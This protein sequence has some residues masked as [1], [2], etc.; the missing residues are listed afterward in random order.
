MATN[1]GTAAS[2][3]PGGSPV[4]VDR[5]LARLDSLEQLVGQLQGDVTKIGNM[6]Q[7]GQMPD[8]KL[9][10]TDTP[11]EKGPTYGQLIEQG[12]ELGKELHK[13][14]EII[15]QEVKSMKG[16][17][18]STL[19]DITAKTEDKVR[20]MEK[21]LGQTGEVLAQHEGQLQGQ[22][23]SLGATLRQNGTELEE[24]LRKSK[25]E[26]EEKLWKVAEEATSKVNEAGNVL[27]LN[28]QQGVQAAASHMEGIRQ[29]GERAKTEIG[30]ILSGINNRVAQIESNIT[31]TG[32]TGQSNWNVGRPAWNNPKEIGDY[33]AVSNL[34]SVPA[35]KTKW[36]WWADKLK[37]V[38]VQVRGEEWKQVLD[39]LEKH[40]IHEDSEELVTTAELWD[41]F[42]RAQHPQLDLDRFKKDIYFILTDKV[43]ANQ[44][45][46]IKKYGSNGIRCYKEL[47]RYSTDMSE[48]AKS[49]WLSNLM[50]PVGANKDEE[51]FDRI[52]KWDQGRREL[53]LVDTEY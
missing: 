18:E 29:E 36:A 24:K 51:L 19:T 6:L 42:V 49:A 40:Q 5:N 53:A 41:E 27:W 16:V 26:L 1:T 11:K 7:T 4:P 25:E 9:L 34:E 2:R 35:E 23:T 44:A 28:Q 38:L 47:H 17:I 12:T 33:R 13:V 52:E 20:E 46:L 50:H 37:C 39:S 30:Q 3:P 8:G 48:M 32:N 22:Q 15:D 31:N 10:G 43:Q 14:K 21:F 45:S